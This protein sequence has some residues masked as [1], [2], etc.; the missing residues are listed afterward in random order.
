M[1]R[2]IRFLLP[3]AEG[4]PLK[5]PIARA[6]PAVTAAAA[7]ADAPWPPRFWWAR[8][9]IVR[10][11]LAG[12]LRGLRRVRS[13]GQGV[14]A[15]AASSPVPPHVLILVRPFWLPAI[16]SVGVVRIVLLLLL[17]LPLLLLPLLLL[18]LLLMMMLILL[19]LLLL[20]LL[21]PL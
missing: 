7:D 4:A 20:L 21:L 11:A 3:L 10:R 14:I 18:P 17:L 2:R 6:V 1:L 13:G 12:P 16:I 8:W 19:L 15:A 5:L 9:T